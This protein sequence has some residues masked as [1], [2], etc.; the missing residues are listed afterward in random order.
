MGAGVSLSLPSNGFPVVI[1]F[2]VFVPSSREQGCY[3]FNLPDFDR[4]LFFLYNPF[5][6]QTG[7]DLGYWEESCRRDSAFAGASIS[8]R[9]DPGYTQVSRIV[10]VT[11]WI[12]DMDLPG[13]FR[14]PQKEK[15][16]VR[17]F[18]PSSFRGVAIAATGLLKKETNSALFTDAVYGVP[19]ITGKTSSA[20]TKM[21]SVS[22]LGGYDLPE[23]RMAIGDGAFCADLLESN[24]LGVFTSRFKGEDR[25]VFPS[26][27]RVAKE[28]VLSP[29]R[30]DMVFADL[31][32]S[33]PGRYR[34]SKGAIYNVAVAVANTGSDDTDADE[35]ADE[36]RS[37]DAPLNPDV[38][39]E[40]GECTKIC[41]VSVSICQFV[42]RVL[43]P[44]RADY[45]SVMV[46]DRATS[47]PGTCIVPVFKLPKPWVHD[48]DMQS[49]LSPSPTSE[50]GKAT[51]PVDTSGVHTQLKPSSGPLDGYDPG[52]PGPVV[53]R[54]SSSTGAIPYPDQLFLFD[55]SFD[56]AVS[57][58]ANV[59]G[60]ARKAFAIS[61]AEGP[62]NAGQSTAAYGLLPWV[63]RFGW[64]SRIFPIR[65]ANAGGSRWGSAWLFAGH[66]WPF[67][68]YL[69]LDMHIIQL[70]WS[71]YVS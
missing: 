25:P 2:E 17:S 49:L 32:S 36:D 41:S 43:P 68:R 59:A 70:L 9:R 35:V 30:A 15:T 52:S 21:V 62:P 28:L 39:S 50:S 7:V 27:G 6:H 13:I 29:F 33:D 26:I 23:V 16:D 53:E 60:T 44:V 61:A 48:L 58:F 5:P 64:V 67:R 3:G 4:I 12:R 37:E 8:G 47:I 65:H 19:D 55:A 10:D 71:S 69:D 46:F 38:R 11:S 42:D 40:N 63:I 24:L 14:S 22:L 34:A 54:E 51:M 66:G 18:H 1:L 20:D 31:A 57:F 56:D 45:I